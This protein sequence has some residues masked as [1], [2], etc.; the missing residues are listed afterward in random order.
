MKIIR[1]ST[2]LVMILVMV[3]SI[4]AP[5]LAV[6]RDFKDVPLYSWYR[7]YVEYTA[8]EGFFQGVSSDLFEPERSLTR[9]ELIT[10]LQRMHKKTGDET[11]LSSGESTAFSDVSENRYSYGAIL[12]AEKN[13]LIEGYPDGTFRPNTPVDRQTLA[14]L[15]HRYL[16]LMNAVEMQEPVDWF[17]A[18]HTAFPPAPEP[19]AL[20]SY[21]DADRIAGWALESV[22]YVSDFRIMVGIET[23][24]S[25]TFQPER[26]ATR[27]ETAAVITRVYQ[28]IHYMENKADL[29]DV[30]HYTY[31]RDENTAPAN[32]VLRE[33]EYEI[34]SDSESLQSL[35]ERIHDLNPDYATP[36]RWDASFFA[37][38]NLLAV[39]LQ[40]A[41]QEPFFRTR[42]T[43]CAVTEDSDSAQVTFFADVHGAGRQGV[44]GDLYL[45]E[46]PK[47]I[48]KASIQTAYYVHGFPEI[49]I[50]EREG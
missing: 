29:Y 42:L 2:G 39:E 13:G 49:I 32:R 25:S 8:Q 21:A 43:E 9:E 11:L 35:L 3:L 27:A 44:S 20:D 15:M 18:M 12:W 34:I 1:K 5:V 23:K 37:D 6:D 31:S 10:V 22:A 16:T 4:A 19:V 24:S 45:I 26:Q 30:L 46:V 7:S 41:A 17:C 50:P 28:A 48:T 36:D 38:K 40:K 33:N 14:T 47:S